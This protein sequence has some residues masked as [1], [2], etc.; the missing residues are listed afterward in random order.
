MS[1]AYFLQVVLDITGYCI[2][3]SY[4]MKFWPRLVVFLLFFA[5]SHVPELLTA[6]G[7]S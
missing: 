7:F 6:L 2:M 4:G 3:A 1:S 5:G